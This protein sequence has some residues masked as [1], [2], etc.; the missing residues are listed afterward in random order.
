MRLTLFP[1]NENYKVVNIRTTQLESILYPPEYIQTDIEKQNRTFSVWH[2]MWSLIQCYWLNKE[3]LYPN[4]AIYWKVL[5]EYTWL[6]NIWDIIMEWDIAWKKFWSIEFVSCSNDYTMEVEY[7]DYLFNI[8][9]QSDVIW[10]D[11]DQYFVWDIKTA[12]ARWTSLE[13][14]IQC[15]MY[16]LMLEQLIDEW[17]ISWFYYFIFLKNKKKW[18]CQVMKYNYDRRKSIKNLTYYLSRYI[19]HEKQQNIRNSYNDRGISNVNPIIWSTTKL[20]GWWAMPRFSTS[21]LPR[22]E[23]VK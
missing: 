16:P 13:K 5:K 10:M 8:N 14:K 6:E 23:E 2:A 11:W 12:S 19:Q 7:G 18:V 3:T 22:E 17:R 20:Q 15:E 9:G 1:L 21:S 4:L